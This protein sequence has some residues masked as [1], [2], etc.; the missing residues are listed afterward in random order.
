MQFTSKI[1]NWKNWRT[2]F[3]LVMLRRIVIKSYLRLRKPESR[4]AGGRRYNT[5]V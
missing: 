1:T 3:G 2:R 5:G 4:A